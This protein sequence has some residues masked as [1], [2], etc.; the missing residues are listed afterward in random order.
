M[1]TERTKVMQ[2]LLRSE[3]KPYHQAW[4]PKVDVYR[5]DQGCLVKFELAGVRDED[6]KV[7]VRGRYLTILGVRRDWAIEEGQ[8][9]YSMEIAYNRFE[10]TIELPC[11]VE[12]A[13]ME[14]EYRDGML[15]IQ[16]KLESE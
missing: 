9:S 3:S 1:T 12:R 13:R 15:L 16:L 11:D 14:T 6:I 7:S 10:R 2:S 8:Q 5:A 4:R